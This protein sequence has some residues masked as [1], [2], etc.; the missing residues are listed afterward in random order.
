MTR[1][2]LALIAA[3]PL[4]GAATPAAQTLP[5]WLAGSWCTAD[6]A[7]GRTCERW[8]PA[9]GGMMIGT[10]QTV[11]GG[12]TVSFEFLRIALD[13]E[14]PVYIAQPGGKAA[15]AFRAVAGEKGV[16]FLNEAHDY[17]QRIRYWRE[18]DALVAEIALKDGT[19]AMSWRYA[20]GE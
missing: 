6:G 14:T 16:T 15:V 18:G 9:A 1:F 4:T 20:R 17:P 12:R 11:K 7:H 19:N 8:G 10:S 3:I 2:A 5:D 13:G